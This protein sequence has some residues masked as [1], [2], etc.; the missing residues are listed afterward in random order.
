MCELSFLL[1]SLH[2]RSL[3]CVAVVPQSATVGCVKEKLA[4]VALHEV[5]TKLPGVSTVLGPSCSDDVKQLGSAA[6]RKSSG[7]DGLII[8][9]ESTATSLSNDT[10]YP[11]VLRTLPSEKWI[12]TAIAALC[13]SLEWTHVAVVHE[14]NLWGRES[15][16]SFLQELARSATT[17]AQW[18]G[19]E[20]S[21]KYKIEV[22]ASAFDPVDILDRLDASL[23]TVVFL[24]IEPERQ[25]ELFAATYAFLRNLP[26]CIPMC[27]L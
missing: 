7:F 21:T 18:A 10:A 25:R 14:P 26:A 12:A 2:A 3:S 19:V 15:A 13:A 24:A 4:R 6:W 27:C 22:N 23:A 9:S 11:N 1:R 8:S 17:D 5:Q 16:E 20:W